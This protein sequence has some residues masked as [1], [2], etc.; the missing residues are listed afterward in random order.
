VEAWRWIDVV[1]LGGEAGPSELEMER[2][3]RGVEEEVRAEEGEEKMQGE[4]E[5]SLERGVETV[6]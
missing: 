6:A 2:G 5:P 1:G 3:E 4:M